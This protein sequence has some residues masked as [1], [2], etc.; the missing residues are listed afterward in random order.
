M[1]CKSPTHSTI[2][3]WVK[4]YGLY[5][6]SEVSRKQE[7]MTKHNNWAIILDESVQFGQEKLL[8]IYGVNLDHIDFSRP[9]EFADLTPLTIK[10]A[11]SWNAE[12][13]KSE[14][15]LIKERIG[16]IKYAV[17]DQGSS[18]KKALKLSEI[19]HVHDVTH[20]ISLI[21]EH[22]YKK[23]QRFVDF[24]KRMAKMRGS[25]CL[26]KVAHVLPPIQRSKARFLN[27][28]STT[29]W[30]MAVLKM[31]EEDNPENNIEI[32]AL[33]WVGDFEELIFELNELNKLVNEIQII[34]KR[35]GI[36]KNTVE[37]YNKILKETYKDTTKKFCE[38]FEEYISQT[39]EM[40]SK[41]EQLLCSSDIIESAF[42]K[43][44]NYLSLNPMLGITN[45]SLCLSA[46][47]M[48]PD[49]C[50]VE[51]IF[52]TIKVEDIKQWTKQN[53]QTSV[54]KKRKE[55]LNIKKSGVKNNFEKH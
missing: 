24:T 50:D 19:P 36:S 20:K 23:D 52:N 37:Q 51:K 46:F 18:I 53:M 44:K 1:Y 33:K 25:L 26:S 13:I 10:A 30:A 17:A 32:D 47:T 11:K 9:L 34:F 28:T 45:L 4:K 15:D 7:E 27:L 54:L 55:V 42:G 39:I 31:L 40:L 43:Y 29:E 35:M 16:K 22:K 8:L 21:M 2:L 41:E 49:T 38:N 5:G 14:I 12:N 3:V 6:L 48:E